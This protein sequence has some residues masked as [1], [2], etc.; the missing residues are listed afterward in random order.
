MIPLQLEECREE[1]HRCQLRAT[2]L[3]MRYQSTLE[4]LAV[5]R[6]KLSTG[7][8]LFS[9]SEEDPSCSVKVLQGRV[10]NYQRELEEKERKLE[11]TELERMELLLRIGEC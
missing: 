5:T 2:E 1:L 9:V 8:D 7:G 4:E 6:T 10:S 3:D 11:K